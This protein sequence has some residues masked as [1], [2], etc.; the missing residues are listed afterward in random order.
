[1]TEEQKDKETARFLVVDTERCEVLG[2]CPSEDSA[3]KQA[4]HEAENAGDKRKV[5][6]V[7]QKIGTVRIE[8]KAAWRGVT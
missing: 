7:Y 8:R 2:V 3:K 6:G 5:I 1:M 4:Q